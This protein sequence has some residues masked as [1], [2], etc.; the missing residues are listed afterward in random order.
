MVCEDIAA[1]YEQA[2]VAALRA[3]ACEGA[4]TVW[5]SPYFA[6]ARM[7]WGCG[8]VARRVHQFPPKV[9]RA[10]ITP[11]AP[12]FP[13]Q[14]CCRRPICPR[15][16]YRPWAQSR[17]LPA[18]SNPTATRQRCPLVLPY[19]NAR[20]RWR[21]AAALVHLAQYARKPPHSWLGHTQWAHGADSSSKFSPWLGH[22]GTRRAR[23]MRLE[24]LS[25]TTAPT[26]APTGCGSSC[27][28]AT[29]FGCCTCNMAQRC[30]GRGAVR[31]AACSAQPARF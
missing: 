10:G 8:P 31:T 30:T 14:T 25:A 27:C 7:P 11:A 6:P 23:F 12:L 29:T 28:G 1:P 22:G 13:C 20:V 2:E 26:T 19:W 4:R 24:P 18:S 9:E 17:A 21:E 3:A 15:P 5:H 16:R